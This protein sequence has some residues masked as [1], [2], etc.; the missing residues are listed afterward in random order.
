MITAKYNNMAII[1][2]AIKYSKLPV[3]SCPPYNSPGPEP[4]QFRKPQATLTP[5]IIAKVLI[6]LLVVRNVF[7]II[8]YFRN[9]FAFNINATL[10]PCVI[11]LSITIC[12]ASENFTF[13]I[14]ICSVPSV[15][16]LETIQGLT[17]LLLYDSRPDPPP[18]LGHIDK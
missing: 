4:C 5:E 9:S 2:D 10:W 12:T 14:S 13:I 6:I 7:I 18:L 1:R 3:A 15:L 11:S 17:P 8:S 16:A